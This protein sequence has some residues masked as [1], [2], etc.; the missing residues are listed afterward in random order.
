MGDLYGNLESMF[1]KHYFRGVVDSAFATKNN[2]FLIQSA[3]T[4][5]ETADASEHLLR[6]ETTAVM[7]FSEWGMRALQ[8]SFPRL[9][10]M[11]DYKERGERGIILNLIPRLNN[12]RSNMVGISQNRNSFITHLEKR[13]EIYML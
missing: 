4:F 3:Q 5:P 7:Q 9:K 12:L 13:P 11:F 8:G 1:T 6:V 10:D 2:E